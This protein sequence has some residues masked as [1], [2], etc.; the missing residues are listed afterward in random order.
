MQ[1]FLPSA[2]LLVLL[3]FPRISSAQPDCGCPTDNWEPAVEAANVIFVG[4]CIGVVTNPIK[5]GLNIVFQVDSSWKRT[6]EPNATIHTEATINCGFPFK[7][8][9]R[10]LVFGNKRHQTIESTRC[11]PNL[12]VDEPEFGQRM[13]Q[14]GNGFIPGERPIGKQMNLLI[15]ILGILSVVTVGFIVLR[16]SIFRKRKT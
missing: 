6:I 4:T 13:A 15:L 2:F 11:E 1:R 10:Y 3:L 5:G 16:K 7:K 9:R 12:A 14:L 8:G